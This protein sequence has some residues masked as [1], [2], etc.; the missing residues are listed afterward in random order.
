MID[1]LIGDATA[2]CGSTT[3]RLIAHICN[4]VGAWGAG[5]VLALSRRWKEPQLAYRTLFDKKLD[6]WPRAYLGQVQFVPI[7]R[8][9]LEDLLTQ[10]ADQ[11]RPTPEPLRA[12]M[13]ARDGLMV[14]NM[15]AQS[16]I[17]K[18]ADG[19]PPIRYAALDQCLDQVGLMA[20]WARASVHMPRIGC[21]LAG[22]DWAMVEPLIQ[23]NL[24]AR[25]VEVT[26]YD[27]H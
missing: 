18:G 11:F 15:I 5:F 7:P 2:P 10:S 17:G 4:D 8:P 23:Q 16:G 19:S 26:V 6:G 24:C 12:A 21:G 1:Y 3:P 25:G 13:F 22:G 20:S 9:P 27:L 14:A